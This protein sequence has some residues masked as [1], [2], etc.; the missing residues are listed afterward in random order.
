MD[1]S[2]SGG[3]KRMRRRGGEDSGSDNEAD[4][5]DQDRQR[6]IDTERAAEGSIDAEPAADDEVAAETD[7]QRSI[8]IEPA[9]DDEAAADTACQRSIDTEPAAVG[10]IDTER[11]AADTARQ[12]SI[13][14]ERVAD[15]DEAATA[16]MAAATAGMAGMVRTGMPIED[17]VMGGL[18]DEDVEDV[19]DAHH[20][21]KVL[22]D[23]MYTDGKRF[24]S[25]KCNIYGI[26]L[27]VSKQLWED[28]HRGVDACL[29]F[30]KTNPSGGY[31]LFRRRRVDYGSIVL[32]LLSSLGFKS[33]IDRAVAKAFDGIDKGIELDV[34]SLGFGQPGV[35]DPLETRASDG[36][37]VSEYSYCAAD[38]TFNAIIA[39][40]RS[41]LVLREHTELLKDGDTVL[42]PDLGTLLRCL[43]C[44][45]HG[46]AG[47]QEVVAIVCSNGAF[48]FKMTYVTNKNYPGVDNGGFRG[49][50]EYLLMRSCSFPEE[51][52]VLQ[53][54]A[55]SDK[56]TT[57]CV[58]LVNGWIYD[59]DGE[60]GGRFDAEEYAAQHMSGVKKAAAVVVASSNGGSPKKK[61]SRRR[62]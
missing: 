6:S 33:V 13:D 38:A 14:T 56:T 18:Q 9:A 21:P 26:K 47:L 60:S 57:H 28:G 59:N 55:S 61:R 41:D 29:T 7:R 40:G 30:V 52:F 8:D 3:K 25:S 16:G 62:K 48:P 5:Q 12:R 58:A 11:A 45:E 54:E 44:D 10:S 24:N 49:K 37:R 27:K 15:D 51:M 17:G 19:A 31:V 34:G 20:Q 39:G 22:S 42:H 46:K 4:R 2:S 50:M 1:G 35:L 53:I 43:A 23:E 32:D 36:V